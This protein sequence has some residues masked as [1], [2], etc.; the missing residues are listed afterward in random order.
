MRPRSFAL[1]KHPFIPSKPVPII[2]LLLDS[3]QETWNGAVL[4]VGSMISP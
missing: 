1:V 2:V 4:V 3:C